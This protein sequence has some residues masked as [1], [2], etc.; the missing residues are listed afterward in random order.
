MKNTRALVMLVV[1][2]LIGIS[3]TALA[4]GWV[5]NK[6]AIASNKVVV[7]VMDIELGSRLNSQMLTTIDWP[8]GSLPEGAFADLKELQDRVVKTSIQRGEALLN[9]KLAP[10]GTQGGLSAV[11]AE[12]KRAMTVRDRK[13]VV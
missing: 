9:S 5:A 11:I 7:A 13:S 3:V 1:S 4:V 2:I 12:G 8:S 6:G 10:L